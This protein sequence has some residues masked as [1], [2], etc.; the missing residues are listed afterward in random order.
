MLHLLPVD[1][2]RFRT[3]TER[4]WPSHVLPTFS[5]AREKLFS[6]LLRQYFFISIFRAC[7][8]SLASEHAS[9]LASM[10][11]A[12]RNIEERLRELDAQFRQRRQDAITAELLDVVAGFEALTR[13]RDQRLG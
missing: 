1:L 10:Q 7:V 3:M 13:S 4:P 9:R 8:Q 5:M 6:A 2:E 12:E 11:A